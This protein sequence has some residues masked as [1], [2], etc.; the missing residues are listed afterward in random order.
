MK[1]SAM[2]AFVMVEVSASC[3]FVKYSRAPPS[4]LSQSPLVSF[5]RLPLDG[6]SAI[7]SRILSIRL[8]IEVIEWLMNKLQ[9]EY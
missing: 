6:S 2:L 8:Q 1:K 9:Q 3:S 7:E 4:F 5:L